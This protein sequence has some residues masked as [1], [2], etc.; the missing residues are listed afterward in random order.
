MLSSAP[1][2]T[3][4][5]VAE[6]CCAQTTGS[7]NIWGLRSKK[8]KEMPQTFIRLGR[9]SNASVYWYCPGFNL[10]FK[11]IVLRVRTELIGYALE[12]CIE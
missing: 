5:T 6:K 4:G 9:G 1:S 12:V 11:N 3:P 8:S 7:T 10:T 2:G